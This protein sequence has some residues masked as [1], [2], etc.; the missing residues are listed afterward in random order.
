MVLAYFDDPREISSYKEI[1]FKSFDA[2]KC[3]LTELTTKS[4]YIALVVGGVDIYVH[5]SELHVLVDHSV[6][7]MYILEAFFSHF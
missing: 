2:V 7:Y 4:A 3:N 5:V 1:Q 6:A